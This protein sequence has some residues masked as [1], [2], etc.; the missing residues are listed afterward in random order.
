M[1]DFLETPEWINLSKK[2]RHRDKKCLRCGSK[3][4]LCA[5]HIIPRHRR[6]DLSLEEFNLQTLCWNCN[7]IKKDKYI[8]SY[9][10]NPS[11]KLLN[12]INNEKLKIQ[13]ALYFIARDQIYKKS[14]QKKGLIDDEFLK[15]FANEYNLITLGVDHPKQREREGFLHGP[16]NLVRFFGI[17]F[18]LL[19]GLAITL[20]REANTLY[21]KHQISEHEIAK[22]IDAEINKVFSDWDSEFQ[23]NIS[24]EEQ[25]IDVS[26][27]KNNA[28]AEID[29]VH[30]KTIKHDTPIQKTNFNGIEENIKYKIYD[31]TYNNGFSITLCEYKKSKI[32]NYT[33]YIRNKKWKNVDFIAI[34]G[35]S[36]NILHKTA[37][38]FSN[39]PD[40]SE[41]NIKTI[42]IK[43]F[44][45]TEYT[46][47]KSREADEIRRNLFDD[48]EDEYMVEV[49]LPEKKTKSYREMLMKQLNISDDQN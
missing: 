25:N 15:N 4:R 1:A 9:L 42:G 26:M 37:L 36:L 46:I 38:D 28:N 8:V 34:E 45:T 16:M 20:V 3:Y 32:K 44:N 30:E 13:S 48:D 11:Q 17:G 47:E 43:V 35:S 10:H 31:R 2:I 19:G 24:E 23:N 14:I 39:K 6:R 41:A 29:L 40:L 18:S 27:V 49:I 7:T 22:Y 5:D 21:G 33:A 12:E